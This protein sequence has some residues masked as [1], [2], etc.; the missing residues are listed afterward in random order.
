MLTAI[1]C[2][3]QFCNPKKSND[4]FLTCKCIYITHNIKIHNALISSKTPRKTCLKKNCQILVFKIFKKKDDWPL[5][6]S[7]IWG[8]S[9]NLDIIFSEKVAVFAIYLQYLVYCSSYNKMFPSLENTETIIFM[10][11]LNNSRIGVAMAVFLWSFE[12]LKLPGFTDF[13]VKLAKIECYLW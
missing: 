13:I 3:V 8:W 2:F 1:R 9:L 10:G 4:L 5:C 7:N 6:V 11:Q 12:G